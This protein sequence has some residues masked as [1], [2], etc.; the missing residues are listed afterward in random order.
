MLPLDEL[1]ADLVTLVR[2]LD[3]I[4][5]ATKVGDPDALTVVVEHARAALFKI[6]TD[7]SRHDVVMSRLVDVLMIEHSL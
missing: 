3:A 1:R 6:Y 4:A 5:L 7:S 2:Y